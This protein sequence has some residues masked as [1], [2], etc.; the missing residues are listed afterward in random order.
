[1]G[2]QP[3]QS[4]D[5]IFRSVGQT[6]VLLGKRLLLGKAMLLVYFG[7]VHDYGLRVAA[8]AR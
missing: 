6:S 4:N 1:M 7:S 8:L 5:L 3:L 2:T